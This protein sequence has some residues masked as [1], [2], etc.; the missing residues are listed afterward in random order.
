MLKVLIFAV[1]FAKKIGKSYS[2][3]PSFPFAREPEK[4]Y[5]KKNEKKTSENIW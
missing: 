1:R 5:K 2:F 3:I 4:R